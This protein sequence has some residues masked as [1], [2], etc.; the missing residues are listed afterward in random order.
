M[1]VPNTKR[2][3]IDKKA[4]VGIVVGISNN[5]KGYRV[6][7]LQ[8]NELVIYTNVM[9][10]EFAIWNQTK[11][12][13]KRWDWGINHQVEIEESFLDDEVQSNFEV[14]RRLNDVYDRCNLALSD[15]SIV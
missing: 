3:K 8:S 14:W 4:N 2:D 5:T 9:I 10:D 1:L 12:E 11:E 6:F 15:S 13:G 7:Q